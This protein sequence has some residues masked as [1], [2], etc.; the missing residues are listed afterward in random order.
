MYDREYAVLEEDDGEFD[1]GDGEYVEDLK[2]VEVFEK[3]DEVGKR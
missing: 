2:G 3:V 1:G